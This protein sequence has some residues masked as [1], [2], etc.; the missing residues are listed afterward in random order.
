MFN[1][2]GIVAIPSRARFVNVTGGL[3]TTELGMAIALPNLAWLRAD[4]IRFLVP[5]TT[6]LGLIDGSATGNPGYHRVIVPTNATHLGLLGPPGGRDFLL[7]PFQCNVT[8][9]LEL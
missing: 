3:V 5:D 4:E 2:V 6:I 7:G 9:E 1:L 8:W